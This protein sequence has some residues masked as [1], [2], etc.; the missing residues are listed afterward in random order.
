MDPEQ[1]V[2]IQRAI[3]LTP[4]TSM[5]LVDGS[6]R[7]QR[8]LTFSENDRHRHVHSPAKTPNGMPAEVRMIVDTRGDLGWPQRHQHRSPAAHR[9]EV[10]AIDAPGYGVPGRISR[11]P[12]ALSVCRLKTAQW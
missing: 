9:Q 3:V 10:L 12:G 11:N 8:G 7:G 6:G 2:G 4:D 5:D 1:K